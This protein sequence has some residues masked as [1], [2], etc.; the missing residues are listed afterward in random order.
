[1]A[2][3]TLTDSRTVDITITPAQQPSD[4]VVHDGTGNTTRDLLGDSATGSTVDHFKVDNDYDSDL[5]NADVIK[6]FNRADGDKIDLPDGDFPS[7]TTVYYEASNALTDD[8]DNEVVLY[9]DQAKTQVIAIIDDAD[10]VPQ[11]DDFLD[12]GIVIQEIT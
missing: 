9:K 4:A 3:D 2:P 5:A 1:M 7:G 10:Y 11:A 12:A 8:A 6:N